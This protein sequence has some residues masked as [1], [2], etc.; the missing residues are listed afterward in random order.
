MG[1]TPCFP[2]ASSAGSGI[3]C[4]EGLVG[5][6]GSLTHTVV[7]KPHKTVFW[8]LPRNRQSLTTAQEGRLAPVDP[9][10]PDTGNDMGQLRNMLK[11]THV[12]S[13]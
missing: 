6:P 3:R 9:L 12:T 2:T 1:S 11:V 7:L 8:V 5:L 13:T 4:S 10:F